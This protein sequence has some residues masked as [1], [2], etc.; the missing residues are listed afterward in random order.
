MKVPE[1]ATLEGSHSRADSRMHDRVMT[2][3]PDRRA[4]QGPGG[5]SIA[6]DSRMHDLRS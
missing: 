2:D 5:A 6:K 1:A 4:C 3:L